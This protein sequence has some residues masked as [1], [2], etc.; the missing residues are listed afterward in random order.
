MVRQHMRE[1]LSCLLETFINECRHAQHYEAHAQEK[2]C[3]IHVH[4]V[5]EVR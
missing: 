5:Q 1:T 3:T 2:V 4:Q